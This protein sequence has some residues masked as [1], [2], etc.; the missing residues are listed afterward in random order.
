MS[1]AEKPVTGLCGIVNV[2]NTCYANSVI[3]A[4]R[5]IPRWTYLIDKMYVPDEKKEEAGVF[6]AYQDL[7]RTLWHPDTVK[8]SRCQPDGFWHTLR[9]SIRGTI[10]E[11]FG[12]NMP[13]DAH[14]FLV[15][16][17]DQCHEVMKYR[18]P[19]SPLY[20]SLGGLTSPVV[21]SIFGW[22]KVDCICENCDN[23][24]SQFEAFNMLKVGLN[25]LEPKSLEELLEEERVDE[26]IDDYT[27]DNC[28]TKSRMTMKRRLWKLPKTLFYVLRRFT[29][30]GRK[31]VSPYSFDGHEICFDRF[32]AEDSTCPSRENKYNVIAMVDHM[33]SHMGGH[34]VAQ[35]FHPQAKQWYLFDDDSSRELDGPRFT[36]LNYILVLTS[37]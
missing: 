6:I 25:R 37:N 32:F 7:A 23:V 21:D 9:N 34:Y 18:A 4:L 31:D 11:S 5:V 14:E 36:P 33:G 30:D 8:G 27:C 20:K 2:G 17:L 10:Y 16:I 1:V 12:Y 24:S 29:P 28:K 15:Y 13:H 22:D 35:V 26:I 19:D 3:Q